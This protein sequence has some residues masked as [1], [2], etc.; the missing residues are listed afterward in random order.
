MKPA[1]LSSRRHSRR[2]RVGP[3]PIGGGSPVTIQSMTTT[4]TRDAAATLDQVRRLAAAGCELVRVAVPTAADAEAI[5]PI[6]AAPELRGGSPASSPR[7]P[8]AEPRHPPADHPWRQPLQKN[9]T[10]LPCGKADISTLR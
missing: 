1:S 9:R 2:V 10:F 4:R 8:A 5:G 7:L 3:V 6:A